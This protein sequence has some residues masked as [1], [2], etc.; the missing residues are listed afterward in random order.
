MNNEE[1]TLMQ[2]VKDGDKLTESERAD[3]V[4]DEIDYDGHDFEMIETI[5]GDDGR[6]Y[7]VM[8][9]IFKLDGQY[10]S[11]LWDRGLTEYQENEYYND[12]IPVKKIEKTVVIANY[13]PL[14]KDE[15]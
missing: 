3:L 5:E 2:K 11:I 4:W 10:Y 15:K 14:K 13:V 1:K 7:R 9:T 8:Q 6:W 12:P